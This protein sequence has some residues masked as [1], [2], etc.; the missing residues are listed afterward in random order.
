LVRVSISGELH[1][2]VKKGRRVY[3]GFF[4]IV[5]DG[6][7]QMN[8]GTRND[9]GGFDGD[10]S[11][12][13]SRTLSII[14]KSGPS[15]LEGSR[16]DGGR[17]LILH[18]VPSEASRKLIL[19]LPIIDQ[20]YIRLEVSGFFDVSGFEVCSNCDYSEILEF[21]PLPNTERHSFKALQG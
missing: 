3:R 4:T 11:I 8:L 18:L 2:R 21:K 15:G 20:E 9:E 14:G 13:F 1:K 19:R 10:K 5:V 17:W 12:T 16:P 7:V 6:K